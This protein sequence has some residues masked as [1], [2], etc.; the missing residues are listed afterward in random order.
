MTV[1]LSLAGIGRIRYVD[2]NEDG[3]VDDKDRTWLG[4]DL[5]KF[6]GGLNIAINYKSLISPC[7]GM[8][9]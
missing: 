4:T 1:S 3:V 9:L 2:L 7:F 5:P 8:V 6:V